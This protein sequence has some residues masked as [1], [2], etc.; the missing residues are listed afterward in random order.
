MFIS[1]VFV[2]K[3]GLGAVSGVGLAF[4]ILI[5]LSVF[6]YT[7]ANM[8]TAFISETLSLKAGSKKKEETF[9]HKW[10]RSKTKNPLAKTNR[11]HRNLLSLQAKVQIRREYRRVVTVQAI[12]LSA[13]LGLLFGL[14]CIGL[15]PEMLQLYGADEEII[16]FGADYLRIVGGASI[17]SFLMAALKGALLGVKDS[18]SALWTSIGMNACNLVLDALFIFVFHF[19]MVGVAC[20]TVLAQFVGMCSLIPVVQRKI[21]HGTKHRWNLDWM[22]MRRLITQSCS[23]IGADLTNEVAMFCYFRVLLPFGPD[24]Y[25][26]SRIV[27]QIK[28]MLMPP[29]VNGFYGATLALVGE[30]YG[31][32][33]YQEVVRYCSWG[34]GLVTFFSAMIWI[35]QFFCGEWIVRLFTDDPEVLE[36]TGWMLSMMVIGDWFWGIASIVAASLKSISYTKPVFVAVSSSSVLLVFLIWLTSKFNWGWQALFYAETAQYV[37]QAMILVVWF[38]S[39]KWIKRRQLSK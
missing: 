22:I 19:G 4:T 29:M 35:F 3:L 8:T 5:V 20:A 1:A 36:H 16:R 23:I 11:K 31:K 25:A 28:K 10:G 14:L 17:F 6:S 24:I 12:Y 13:G 26:A 27:V 39:R 37:F 7:I 21:F 32:R 30:Q 33:D 38:Y 9:L 18:K 15:A 34:I 2:A